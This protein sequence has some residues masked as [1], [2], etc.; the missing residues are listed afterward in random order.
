MNLIPASEV[1]NDVHNM[2]K[3]YFEQGLV[4][5]SILY[6]VVDEV[7][8]V[9]GLRMFPIK[10][11]SL[12]IAGFKASLP[13]DFHKLEYAVLCRKITVENPSH[14]FHITEQILQCEDQVLPCEKLYT[15]ELGQP[16]R[17]IQK[18]E[19]TSIEFSD[20]KLLKA[21]SKTGCDTNCQ[22][23]K[24][25]SPYEF[26]V[27]NKELVFN[28][29]EGSVYIEYYANPSSTELMISDHP[30]IKS[31]IREKCIYECLKQLAFNKDAQVTNMLQFQQKEAQIA[32]MNGRNVLKSD[33]K[34]FYALANT[35]IRKYNRTSPL[36]NNRT[37]L[38]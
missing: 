23:L 18:F 4:D 35:L 25:N 38:W 14:N 10:E 1:L 31:W 12:S 8:S 36:M 20:F 22:N 37:Y 7:N 9:V 34:E 33:I 5:D 32:E 27:I 11:T 13:E 2:L 29:Q 15:N 30:R 24:A 6:R 19:T 28:I 21:S 26:Q 16:T 17:F 3:T